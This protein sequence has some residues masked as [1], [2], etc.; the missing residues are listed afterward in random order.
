M[1]TCF[2]YLFNRR[3]RDGGSPVMPVQ[4]FNFIMYNFVKISGECEGA[5]RLAPGSG[6]GSEVEGLQAA[7]FHQAGQINQAVGE[8][9]FV[10]VPGKD[11]DHIAANHQRRQTVNDR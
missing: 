9:P 1:E 6:T 7:L 2:M 10:I 8:R 5:V 4:V 11:F 3:L